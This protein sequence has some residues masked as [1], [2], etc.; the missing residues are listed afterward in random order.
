MAHMVTP[1]KVIEKAV[2]ITEEAIAAAT[3][4]VLDQALGKNS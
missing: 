3:S 4:G 2:E 1:E